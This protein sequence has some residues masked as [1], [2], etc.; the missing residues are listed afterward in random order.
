MWIAILVIAVMPEVMDPTQPVLV[1]FAE[2]QLFWADSQADALA[3]CNA[4]AEKY[5][6]YDR[7]GV[8]APYKPS[9]DPH[10]GLPLFETAQG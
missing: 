2:G 10:S 3:A 7:V 8:C 6:G 5:N 9:H 4:A 1:N